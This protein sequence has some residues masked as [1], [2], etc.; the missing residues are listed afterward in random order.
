MPA[1]SHGSVLPFSTVRE[2]YAAMGRGNSAGPKDASPDPHRVS[3]RLRMPTVMPS[4][5]ATCPAFGTATAE[6]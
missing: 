5:Y 3:S 2:A 6:T 1:A 4:P